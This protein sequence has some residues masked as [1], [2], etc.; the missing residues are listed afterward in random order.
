MSPNPSLVK[1]ICLVLDHI[2]QQD[3]KKN[4][5][6]QWAD[7]NMELCHLCELCEQISPGPI[8]GK[9]YTYLSMLISKLE[10]SDTELIMAAIYISRLLENT[11]AKVF[12][13]RTWQRMLL[14]ACMIACKMATEDEKYIKM[15]DYM[16]CYPLLDSSQ[17][18]LMEVQFFKLIDFRAAVDPAAYHQAQTELLELGMV[19]IMSPLCLKP[20]D[21][22]TA[23]RRCSLVG[24][25]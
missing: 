25:A 22:V 18:L 24:A 7:L 15:K 20:A 19:A 16:K 11:N 6:D 8:M 13:G 2:L 9:I 23:L 21:I 5:S 3:K 14:S 12:T 1:A 17:M 10:L 4:P